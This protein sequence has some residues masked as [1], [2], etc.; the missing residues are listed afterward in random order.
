MRTG[1][2]AELARRLGVFYSPTE[3]SDWMKSPHPQLGGRRPVDCQYFEVSRIID[4]LESGAAERVR[5]ALEAAET[6]EAAER[7]K[8]EEQRTEDCPYYAKR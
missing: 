1:D 8:D 5:A 3:V 4:R 2:Y 7:G 6:V